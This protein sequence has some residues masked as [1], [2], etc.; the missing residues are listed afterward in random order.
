M[1]RRKK[2]VWH[3]Q[4]VSSCGLRERETSDTCSPSPLL[5]DPRLP[6][7][8]PLAV[9]CIQ[10]TQVH[11]R[12]PKAA[13]LTWAAHRNRDTW[14]PPP[15][16]E[17]QAVSMEREQT[18]G[19]LQRPPRDCSVQP[20][21]TLTALGRVGFLHSFFFTS[22]NNISSFLSLKHIMGKKEK[23]K[24]NCH[25]PAEHRSH[26]WGGISQP[27]VTRAQASPSYTFVYPDCTAGMR[28]R[29]CFLLH[30]AGHR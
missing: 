5:G 8:Y 28:T 19:S 27:L 20:N 2:K 26:S 10:H 15:E 25:G 30:T 22:T 23:K 14:A 4:F 3:L 12:G 7:Y 21:L 16:T 1:Q 11:P 13:V 18:R 9:T 17:N 29:L 6:A 24:K